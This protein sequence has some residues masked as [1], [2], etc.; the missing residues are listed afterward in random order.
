[1]MSPSSLLKPVRA[2]IS[3]RL[4]AFQ[5]GRFA[6]FLLLPAAGLPQASRGNET[7][8]IGPA[9]GNWNTAASWD[10]QVPNATLD[11]YVDLFESQNSRVTAN[12][13]A[14]VKNLFIGAGDELILGAGSL[15]VYGDTI[16]NA[17]TIR[18]RVPGDT[19]GST[20]LLYFNS[21]TTLQ[22]AGKLMLTGAGRNV[23]DD[24]GGTTPGILTV[25]AGQEIIT[26]ANTVP[27][28]QST[29]LHVGIVNYGTITADQGGVTLYSRPKSNHA[30]FRAINGGRLLIT[31]SLLTNYN[32]ATDTLTGGRWEVVSHGTA[33]TMDFSSAPVATIAAS[34]FVRLSGAGATLAQLSTLTN[35]SG[36]LALENGK[37]LATTGNMAIPGTLQYCLAD[38][39]GFGYDRTRLAITG[40]VNFTGTRVDILD[41]GLTSGSYLLATWTGTLTGAPLLG[42]FPPGSQ[43]S[44]VLDTDAKT[45]CLEIVMPPPIRFTGFNLAP[46]SGPNA[47]LTVVSLTATGQPDAS[48]AAMSSLDMIGWTPAAPPLSSPAGELSWQI[49]ESG[50]GRRFYRIDRQ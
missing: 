23:I 41:Q 43:S 39:I 19:S 49:I 24:L 40:D 1:M 37:T 10:P 3:A 26:D 29:A 22:G 30:L 17:G 36:T 35:V 12:V 47:G 32:A 11:A 2:A 48:Y 20:R 5:R 9:T 31:G 6:I 42:S 8:W 45:L 25:G 38:G 46:G 14:S 4:C 50:T 21:A 16:N 27:S 33:T 15:T 28:Y 13:T 34:T 18:I 7:V 44:L